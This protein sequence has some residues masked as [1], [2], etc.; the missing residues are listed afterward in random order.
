MFFYGGTEAP[1]GVFELDIV[2]GM[3]GKPVEVVE[4]RFTGLPFPANAEIVLEGFVY[5]DKT[6]L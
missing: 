2:G 6:H 5:P 1:Y 3:R 4:G